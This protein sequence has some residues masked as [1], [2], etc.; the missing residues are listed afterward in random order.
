MNK[1]L[2]KLLF[3][4][5]ITSIFKNVNSH[6]FWI[7]P[8][9]YHLK[10]DNQISAKLLIGENFIGS[11]FPY[12]KK[13]YQIS[14]LYSGN[15]KIKIKGRLGDLPALNTITGFTGLNILQVISAMNYVDYEGF[16]KFS[17]AQIT[18]SLIN[19]SIEES[20]ES[21]KR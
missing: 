21:S 1:K 2:T 9:K 16:L 13:E 15:K 4:I 10:N 20:F 19:S 12:S 18:L 7:D 3:I 5:I 17:N 14:N 11:E 8:I 6:E